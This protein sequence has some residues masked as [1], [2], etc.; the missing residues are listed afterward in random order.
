MAT[1]THRHPFGQVL[2]RTPE[3]GP[4]CPQPTD[5][6]LRREVER[7]MREGAQWTDGNHNVQLGILLIP[8]ADATSR[9]VALVQEERK[10]RGHHQNC[11]C[12]E[13]IGDDNIDPRCA[14][15]DK[16]GGDGE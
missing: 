14:P 13:V 12:G 4:E 16:S 10:A 8:V 15:P 5:S 9:A 3:C 2:E 7:I 6:T 1:E 11:R